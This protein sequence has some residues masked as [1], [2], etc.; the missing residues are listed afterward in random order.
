MLEGEGLVSLKEIAQGDAQGRGGKGRKEGEIN[1]FKIMKYKIEMDTWYDRRSTKSLLIYFATESK[2]T[3]SRLHILPRP[4]LPTPN[5][6]S[7]S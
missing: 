5:H 2:L 4:P 7:H 1:N 6:S 3:Y